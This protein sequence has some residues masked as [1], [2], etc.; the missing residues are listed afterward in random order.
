MVTAVFKALLTCRRLHQLTAWSLHQML[1]WY[2]AQKLSNSPKI[3]YVALQLEHEDQKSSEK[4]LSYGSAVSSYP[5]TETS[6][7]ISNSLGHKSASSDKLRCFSDKKTQLDWQPLHS[8]EYLWSYQE[9]S[10]KGKTNLAT[11]KP[12][13]PHYAALQTRLADSLV[14]SS[15]KSWGIL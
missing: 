8:L 2:L 13:N 14:F 4:K 15:N 6:C 1:N 12:M 5:H 10:S 9:F 3:R 7:T 11:A